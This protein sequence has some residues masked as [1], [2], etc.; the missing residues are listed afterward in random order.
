M[1][2]LPELP[3]P[4]RPS[5]SVTDTTEDYTST[6]DVPGRAFVLNFGRIRYGTKDAIQ[7]ASILL[8]LVMLLMLAIAFVADIFTDRAMTKDLLNWITTPLMLAIG[9]AIGRS[10]KL[11]Q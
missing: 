1:S 6:S 3:P 11:P 7:G 8:A 10:D 5:A 4:E 9:V 2:D